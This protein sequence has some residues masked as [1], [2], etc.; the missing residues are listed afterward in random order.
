VISEKQGVHEKH[1]MHEMK[2]PTRADVG[3]FVLFRVFRGQWLFL[4]SW[5]TWQ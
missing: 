1:E 5:Q 4:E 2:T 3:P